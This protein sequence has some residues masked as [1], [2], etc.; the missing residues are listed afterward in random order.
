MASPPEHPLR[1]LGSV[2]LVFA[3]SLQVLLSVLA[4]VSAP[5]TLE[6]LGGSSERSALMREPRCPALK[7]LRM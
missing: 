3:T 2:V 1:L 7:L 5:L 4:L 6:L